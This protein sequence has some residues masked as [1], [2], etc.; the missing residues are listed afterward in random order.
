MRQ[1]RVW[2]GS[3]RL[4]EIDEI[5]RAI[6]AE[7]PA[8]ARTVIRSH[9][10]LA[11]PRNEAFLRNPDAREHHQTHWHQWGIL[12][13]TRKFLRDLDT[14]VPKYLQ[15]WGVWH[16]VCDVLSEHIDGATRWELLHISVLLHDIGKFGARTHG[17]SGFHFARHEELSRRVIACEL[18]LHRFG[19]TPAQISYVSLTAGDHF[20]LGLVRQKA[21]QAGEYNAEFVQSSQFRT[22]CEMVIREHPE[23]IIEI[24]VLFLGDSLSKA[25][26][27]N[28][29]ERALSQYDLNVAVAHRYLDIAALRLSRPGCTT[30]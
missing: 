15:E 27:P 16:L 26:P 13:H 20:V 11:V 14:S 29:P 1:S 5:A 8:M 4:P 25:E 7:L 22:L 21:R 18:D 28:G 10:D 3:T 9:L 30:S 2:A 12:T 23:D 17:P 6:D 24:G 19:L